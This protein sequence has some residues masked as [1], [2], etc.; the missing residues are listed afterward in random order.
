MMDAVGK[1]SSSSSLD[2]TSPIAARHAAEKVNLLETLNHFTS[3]PDAAYLHG[4]HASESQK[5]S[6]QLKS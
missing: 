6:V 3:S 2:R 4:C 1:S 5:L